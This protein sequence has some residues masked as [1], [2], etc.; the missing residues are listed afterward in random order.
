MKKVFLLISVFTM[1]TIWSCK[2]KTTGEHAKTDSSA[3]QYTCPM[4]PEVLFD[5]PGTC[6][7]CGME[8]IKKTSGEKMEMPMDMDSTMHKDSTMKM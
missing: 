4:H 7:K 1:I 2:N 8:L 5:K 3:M 6:P